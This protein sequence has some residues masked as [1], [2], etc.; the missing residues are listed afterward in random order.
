PRLN[1]DQYNAID[2]IKKSS[3]NV[4]LLKGVTGSGKTEVYM[5]L[6]NEAIPKEQS[7]IVLVP[8]I[9]LTPQMIERFK[10][11]FGREVAVFHSRLSDGERYD[12]WYRVKA[13]KAKLVIGA[14]SALFL[15]VSNLGLIIIDE[16]HENT[17]K[18]EQNP[19]YQA[20]E[21]A[22]FI[23]KIRGC[24]VILGSATPSI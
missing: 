23:S 8:E 11:R 1:D 18:S 21:V 13:G 2:I 6:V 19:K 17:Y 5:S 4:F 14:R 9:S 10:G 22:E 24:K 12:E 3:N 7:S 20:R 15:P 16:E